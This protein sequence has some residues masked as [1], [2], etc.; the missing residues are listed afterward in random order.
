VDGFWAGVVLVILTVVAFNAV[1][2]VEDAALRRLAYPKPSRVRIVGIGLSALGLLA[3]WPV[4]NT[5]GSGDLA[6]LVSAVLFVSALVIAGQVA[7]VAALLFGG[8]LTQQYV[9]ARRGQKT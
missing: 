9:G 5:T 1:G 8:W 4:P 7:A 6:V 2:R 3:G